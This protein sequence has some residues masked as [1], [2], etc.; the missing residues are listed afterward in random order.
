MAI[1]NYGGFAEGFKGGFGLVN[2]VIDRKNKQTNIEDAAETQKTQFG[3]TLDQ[4]ADEAAATAAWRQ[5]DLQI[6]RDAALRAAGLNATRAKTAGVTA[7]TASIN[8]RTAQKKQDDL[9]DPTSLAYQIAKQEID[10]GK[11][12][13][14]ELERKNAVATRQDN[15]FMAATR[16]SELY[17]AVND[18]GGI[19]SDALYDQAME[20][21][22]LNKDTSFAL[23]YLSSDEAQQDVAVLDEFIA[24]LATGGS[25]EASPKVLKAFDQTFNI[26]QSANLGAT[27]NAD[28]TNAPL[29]MQAGGKFGDYKIIGQGLYQLDNQTPAPVNGKQQPSAIGGTLYVMTQNNQGQMIP[30]FPPLTSGRSNKNNTPLAINMD[31][32]L[33]A[34]AGKAYMIQQVGA[35]IKPLVRDAVIKHR[36]GNNEGGNGVAEYNTEVK[37]IVDQSIRGLQGGSTNIYMGSDTGLTNQQQLEPKEIDKMRAR[38]QEHQVYGQVK[39]P[40]KQQVMDWL[41]AEESALK[42]FRV[43]GLRNRGEKTLGEIVPPNAWTPQLISALSTQIGEGKADTD[44]AATSELIDREQFLQQMGALNLTSQL[45]F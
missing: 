41:A 32:A 30:Y 7:D 17:K 10:K 45:E 12:D 23:G 34:T 13:Q 9:S 16:I 39:E 21:V 22:D 42:Q 33:S 1:N 4:K 18:S 38:V 24:G 27:I 35:K 2:D 26:N 6:K 19:Y 15:N 11:I 8:A 29:A 37:R 31:H 14:K 28:F 5:E 44:G 43:K 20:A 3:L 25:V 36:F 40:Q